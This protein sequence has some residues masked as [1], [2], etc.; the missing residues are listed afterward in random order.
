MLGLG[1]GIA[2]EVF[3]QSY[4]EPTLEITECYDYY[5][6]EIVGETCLEKE[7][8]YSIWETYAV[9][10][11]GVGAGLLVCAVIYEILYGIFVGDL[12]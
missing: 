4:V 7:W 12:E 6:N 10:L 9:I 11:A 3:I 8:E 5:R 1:I 2:S